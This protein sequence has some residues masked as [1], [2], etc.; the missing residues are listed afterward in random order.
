VQHCRDGHRGGREQKRYVPGAG[1]VAKL[2]KEINKG[3]PGLE[4]K[5][6]PLSWLSKN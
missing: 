4:E 1:P 6:V 2:P 3:H 5:K